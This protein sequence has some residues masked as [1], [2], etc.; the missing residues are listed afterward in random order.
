AGG[1]TIG[2]SSIVSTIDLP[3]NLLVAS[4]YAVGIPKIKEMRVAKDE[5]TML[6]V[7]ALKT[8]GFLN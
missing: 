1:R 8:C 5:V 7:K 4:K 6:T 2:I 3:G